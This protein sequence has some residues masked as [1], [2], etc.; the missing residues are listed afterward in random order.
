MSAEPDNQYHH[1]DQTFVQATKAVLTGSTP[2]LPP[3]TLLR[4]LLEREK[5]AQVQPSPTFAQF[6]GTWQLCFVTGT[7]KPHQQKERMIGNGFYIPRW[8]TMQ[9]VYSPGNPTNYGPQTSDK[10]GQIANQ[11]HWGGLSLSLTGPARCWAKKNIMAFD[12]T[13]IEFKAF[14]KTLYQ[15]FIRGG[16]AGEQEF[17]QG[18]VRTQAF[19]VY[20]LIH[21]QVLAA[22]GRGGGI[23]LWAKTES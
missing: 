12:F 1:L 20:Y 23:A 5:M 21:Q 14:G 16:Q 13:R 3:Q 22:R 18:H 17:W 9:I 15:G 6:I 2:K 4:S 11:V 8:V 7:H 19:F 10:V